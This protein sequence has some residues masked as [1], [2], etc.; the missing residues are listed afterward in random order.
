MN[1]K[2]ITVCG[3]TR[4]LDVSAVVCWLLEREENAMTFG[5]HSL[6]QW[7]PDCPPHHLAEHEG[8]ADKF[9]KLHLAKIDK[10]DEVFVVDFDGYIGPSSLEQIRH[11][12]ARGIRVRY[13]S[14][15]PVGAM[16]REIGAQSLKNTEAE[17]Q[18]AYSVC[19]MGIFQPD[20]FDALSDAG[21]TPKS[22]DVYEV[23]RGKCATY[24]ASEFLSQT[25]IG[26]ILNGLDSNSDLEVGESADDWP[27]DL[28]ADDE[29]ALFKK[30]S[31][32]VD[33]WAASTQN[34][35][36]FS[37]IF[38]VVDDRVRILDVDAQTF[39]VLA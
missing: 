5:L 31:D 18:H 20:L 23:M 15:D 24:R 7:Y 35:P 14:N 34:K 25:I 28:S 37:R 32:A 33:D 29:A 12:K 21:I 16:V 19:D 8:V 27:K 30:V 9:G 17:T 1:T 4:Y 26:D 2:I 6:P 39:E 11:A 13:F 22:G 10:S 36:G 38:D 3:S